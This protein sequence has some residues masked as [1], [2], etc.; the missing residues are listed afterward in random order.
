MKKANLLNNVQNKHTLTD[1]LFI[2]AIATCALIAVILPMAPQ[3]FGHIS[4]NMKTN[5]IIYAS[6]TFPILMLL[7]KGGLIAIATLVLISLNNTRKLRKTQIR[8]LKTLRQSE[9]LNS[10]NIPLIIAKRRGY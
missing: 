4:T 1:A 6:Y 3:G 9:A 7:I 8:V 5:S 10:A 2:L